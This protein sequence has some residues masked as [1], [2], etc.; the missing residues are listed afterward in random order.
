MRTPVAPSGWPMAMA[1]PLGLYFSRSGRNSRAHISAMAAK[2]SL[3]SI[4]SKSSMVMPERASSLRVTGLGADSTSTGS[5]APTANCTK[6]ARI[7]SPRRSAVARDLPL[8]GENLRDLELGPQLPVDHPQ[9][10]LAE[11]SCPALGV[12]RHRRPAHRLDPAR[13]R[14]VVE[15]GHHA[16][17]DEVHGLLRRS[18]LAVDR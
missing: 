14:D 6:R 2:A 12:R 15:P 18:A 13:D 16:G 1:P 7:G 5:S 10:V 8:V 4:A 9:E 11:R 17:G 3:H